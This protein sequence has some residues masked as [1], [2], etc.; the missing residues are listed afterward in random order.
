MNE[1]PR[2]S[3][4]DSYVQVK[5]RRVAHLKQAGRQLLQLL[6]QLVPDLRQ[7]LTLLVL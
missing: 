4:D 3:L 2:A 5:R 6:L 1:T 7:T